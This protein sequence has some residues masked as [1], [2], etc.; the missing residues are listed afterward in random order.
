MIGVAGIKSH[1][2]SLPLMQHVHN[3]SSPGPLNVKWVPRLKGATEARRALG[4][5]MFVKP[6]TYARKRGA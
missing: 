3:F 4:V 2:H 1:L 6:T 5:V